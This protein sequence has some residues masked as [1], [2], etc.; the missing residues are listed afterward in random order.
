MTW[1]EIVK[2]LKCPQCHQKT[3]ELEQYTQRPNY[4]FAHGKYKCTNCGY[5][6]RV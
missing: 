4:K 3:L 6:M 2:A 5:E 1:F